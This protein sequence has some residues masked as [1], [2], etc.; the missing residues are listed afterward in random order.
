MLDLRLNK[1]RWETNVKN[2]V[3]CVE[4]DRKDIEANKL[5]V[6]TLE[7]KMHIFDLRTQHPTL[8]FSSMTQPAHDS[9]VWTGRHLPQNRDIWMT[10]GGNGSLNLWK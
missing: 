2:G 8:G 6:T 1:V 10:T 4:F 5:L 9:T 7:A 3:C